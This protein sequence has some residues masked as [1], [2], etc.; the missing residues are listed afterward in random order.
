M[1]K[2]L[3][4]IGAG[5]IFA[6]ALTFDSCKKEDDVDNCT[7]LAQTLVDAAQIYAD[8]PTNVANCTSYKTAI[9]SYFEGCDA[10]SDT[11]K[12]TYQLVYDYLTCE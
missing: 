8:D 7:S 1:K 2:F 11:D 10:I 12:A 6:S 4:I 5:L 3:S 9:K